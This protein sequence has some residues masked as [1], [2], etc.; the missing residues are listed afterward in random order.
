[1]SLFELDGGG[2][3]GGRDGAEILVAAA[4]AELV[5]VKGGGMDERPIAERKEDWEWDKE[6]WCRQPVDVWENECI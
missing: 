2:S 1:M 3:D 6:W 5:V 4:V